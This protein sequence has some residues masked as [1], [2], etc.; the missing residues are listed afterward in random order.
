[1]PSRVDKSISR[2]NG[3]E[4]LDCVEQSRLAPFIDFDELIIY[5]NIC[6]NIIMSLRYW[7]KSINAKRDHTAGSVRDK[8]EGEGRGK[9]R[10]AIAL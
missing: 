10:R 2:Y 7:N 9:W 5:T 8:S 3:L 4:R 1:M 6:R